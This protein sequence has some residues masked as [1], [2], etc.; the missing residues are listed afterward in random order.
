[1]KPTQH[2]LLASTLLIA[3]ATQ[4]QKVMVEETKEVFA[5]GTVSAY[6][7]TIPYAQ[8]NDVA[9][10]WKKWQKER[11]GIVK[12]TK[13][14]C[15]SDNTVVTELGT[16][17]VDI[18]STLKQKDAQTLELIVAYDFDGKY[19]NGADMPEKATVV[20]TQLQAFGLR[21]AVNEENE[22]LKNNNKALEKLNNKQKDLEKDNA[23]YNKE[24]AKNKSKL[25]KNSNELTFKEEALTKKKDEVA[26]QK[27]VV[28][29]SAA[30]VD[31]QA[32]ASKKIYEK[33]KSAQLDLE[34]DIKNLKNSNVDCKDA[35]LK[36]EGK[37]TENEAAQV[38]NKK[39]IADQTIQVEGIV[40]KIKMLTE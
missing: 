14:N 31:E 19:I 9:K 32:K 29:A 4:A 11:K 15:F 10:E 7:T 1:M 3:T 28:D 17:T 20:K 2:I 35:I 27:R 26:I 24:I 18:Y 8:L 12:E 39:S 23:D 34:K 16:N 36:N 40:A 25:E 22:Q 6:K 30:A 33:L 37:L 13:S 21:L 38:T 5:V